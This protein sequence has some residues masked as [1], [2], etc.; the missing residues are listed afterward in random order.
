M[1]PQAIGISQYTIFTGKIEQTTVPSAH[2]QIDIFVNPSLDDSESFGVSVLEASASGVPV[3]VSNV[4]GLKEVVK[5]LEAGLIVPPADTD[6]LT[7]AIAYLIL[8]KDERIRLGSNGIKHVKTHYDWKI[9]LED[10]VKL[11]QHLRLNAIDSHQMK[12]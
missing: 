5:H 7:D 10:I 4:G 1:S 8:H 3:V 9:N 6:K 11:Y 2:R 12:N